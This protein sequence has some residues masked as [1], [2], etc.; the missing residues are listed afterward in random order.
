[1]DI[2]ISKITIDLCRNEIHEGGALHVARMLSSVRHLYLSGN[3]I[4]DAGASLISEAARGSTTLKTLI[5]NDCSIASRGVE[6]FSR[7]LRV[8]NS[9]LE[10][11]D[12]TLNILRDQGIS[13]VAEALKQNEQLKELWMGGCG[14]TDK[15][16]AS[17]ASALTIN[18]SLKML[19]IGGNRGVLT[20]YG[21]ASIAHSLAN[22]SVFVKLAISY[23]FGSTTADH[24]DREVNEARKRN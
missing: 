15:G 13:N 1:M 11:L 18:N 7:A 21:L 22:K 12:I 17:L 23:D 4:G 9:S 24:L 3:P 20:E 16:A 14:L 8:Y 10:K 2:N 6:D 19:H 5:L